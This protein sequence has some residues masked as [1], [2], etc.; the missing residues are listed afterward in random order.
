MRAV[1]SGEKARLEGLKIAREMLLE[2][3][4]LVQGIQIVAPFSRYAL[5]VEVVEVL[6]ARTPKPI[7]G[8]SLPESQG[9]TST[10]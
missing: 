1:E 2:L 3:Q 9:R 5:A 4:E 10:V 8:N 6:S 7:G